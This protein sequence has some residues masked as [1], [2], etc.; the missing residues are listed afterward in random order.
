MPVITLN[1]TIP[2]FKAEATNKE[3]VNFSQLR[4]KFIVLYFYPKDNTP[5]CTCEAENFRDHYDQF[6]KLNAVIYGISRDTLASHEKFKAKYQL[7]FELISDRD[8]QFCQTF[9]VLRP[10]NMFGKLLNGIQRS[11][12]LIDKQGV[13]R[14]EWR[15]VDV[16]KHVNEVLEALKVLSN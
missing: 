10:K 11:T 6:K 14:R 4:G 9:D 16:K 1:Q 7:P 12:F 15:K 5:G 13:L 8:E 2:D 3:I